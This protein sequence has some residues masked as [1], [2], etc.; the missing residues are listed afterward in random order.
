MGALYSEAFGNTQPGHPG[1]TLCG[2]LPSVG[3][4]RLLHSASSPSL[5]PLPSS[6]PTHPALWRRNSAGA[7]THA[8]QSRPTAYPLCAHCGER[9]TGSNAKCRVVHRTHS[10]PSIPLTRG[11]RR[12]AARTPISQKELVSQAAE[13]IAPTAPYSFLAIKVISFSLSFFLSHHQTTGLPA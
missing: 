13:V 9:A 7:K 6:P 8:L 3:D 2:A 11:G 1:S 10:L 5:I 12:W 4:C